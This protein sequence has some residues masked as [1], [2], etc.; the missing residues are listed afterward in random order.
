[1]QNDDRYSKKEAQQ[2]FDTALQ[3]AF[4]TPHRPLKTLTPK[5]PTKQHKGKKS[6]ASA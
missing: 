5:R 1:M 6:K 3:G 4:A 2:R